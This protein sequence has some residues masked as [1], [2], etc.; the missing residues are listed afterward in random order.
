LNATRQAAQNATSQK[1]G[2]I[3]AIRDWVGQYYPGTDQ[4]NELAVFWGNLAKGLADTD[5]EYVFFEIYVEPFINDP[6]AWY[7][8]QA[9]I[10]KNIRAQAPNHTIIAEIDQKTWFKDT[11]PKPD[12]TLMT[13]F[14][15]FKPVTDKNVVYTYTDY[16][17][18]IFTHQ[19]ATSMDPFFADLRGVPYPST[20]E[21]DMQLAINRATH[22]TAKEALEE[23]KADVFSW[24]G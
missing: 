19:G 8:L 16:E 24:D 23:Y 10:V 21:P 13:S 12:W 5:P 9:Q 18:M 17:S 6:Y 15:H 20:I 7:E 2:F 22:P 4:W 1:M 3:V 14:K 11:M